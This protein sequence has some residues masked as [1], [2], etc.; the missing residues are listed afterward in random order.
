MWYLKGFAHLNNRHISNLNSCLEVP[1]QIG[2]RETWNL[3]VEC[4]HK[5][6]DH[7]TM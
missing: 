6:L 3:P 2:I 5:T 7:S 4:A 1:Q